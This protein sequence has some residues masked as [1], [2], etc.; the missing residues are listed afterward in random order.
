MR[1]DSVNAP[2]AGSAGPSRSRPPTTMEADSSRP[3]S[4]ASWATSNAS[5]PSP[6]GGALAKKTR[7]AYSRNDSSCAGYAA[8]PA[9]TA[10]RA[11]WATRTRSDPKVRFVSVLLEA[12]RL[13]DARDGRASSEELSVNAACADQ[14]T[15]AV[16][17]C[18]QPARDVTP[19]RPVWK[20]TSVGR[21]A[22]TIQHERAVFDF[23]AGDDG[24]CGSFVPRAAAPPRRFFAEPAP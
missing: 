17:L 8:W 21:N 3:S 10:H 19:R 15:P 20:S 23:H 13:R 24:V 7:A 2:R 1:E 5:R 9:A 12:A 14:A 16:S 4:C 22:S 18:A 11:T 6:P